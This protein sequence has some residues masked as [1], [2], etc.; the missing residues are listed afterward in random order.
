MNFVTW[1]P[2]L[3]S[4]FLTGFNAAIFIVIKFNDLRHLGKSL[5]EVKDT[6]KEITKK[7][8]NNAERISAQEGKCKAT[9]G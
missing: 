3:I 6:L 5:D 4:L 1:I 8:D 9:H 7:L 2:I